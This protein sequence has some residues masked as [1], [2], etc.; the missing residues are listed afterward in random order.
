MGSVN[1][2]SPRSLP[3]SGYFIKKPLVSSKTVD[4]VWTTDISLIS[5]HIF[6]SPAQLELS[7]QYP[8]PRDHI[9]YSTFPCLFAI[10]IIVIIIIIIIINYVVIVFE[11]HLLCILIQSVQQDMLMQRHRSGSANDCLTVTK[12]GMTLLLVM[13]RT[14]IQLNSHGYMPIPR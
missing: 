13:V 7:A 11:R 2:V 4:S 6:S 9:F 14:A 5:C 12:V 10:I 1:S 3:S 8:F